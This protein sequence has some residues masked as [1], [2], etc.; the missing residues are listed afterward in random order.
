MV[1]KKVKLL[2]RPEL[3]HIRGQAGEFVSREV[4]VYEC[5]K[6][7]NLPRQHG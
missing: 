1:V 4:E 3:T 7:P 5:C 2:K 6:L